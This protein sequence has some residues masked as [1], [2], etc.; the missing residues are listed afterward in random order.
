M[1]YPIL[2]KANATDFRSLGLGVLKDAI[3]CLVTEERNG[4]FELN[5]IY[6][7]SGIHADQ[8]EVDLIIKVDTGHSEIS[9]DQR[10]RI[11]RID[12]RMDGMLEVYANHVSYLAQSLVLEPVVKIENCSAQRALEIW[13]ENMIGAHPFTVMSDIQTSRSTTLTITNQ[14][15]AWQALGGAE[16]SIQNIW[17][18]EYIFDNYRIHLR[19]NRGGNANTLISYGRNL[20]DL[21]QEENI[22][23][24]FTSIY[25]YAIFRDNEQKETILTLRSDSTSDV[26]PILDSENAPYFAHRRVLPIDFSRAFDRGEVLTNEAKRIRLRELAEAYLEEH[27]IGV[28]QVSMSL[29]FV[30][31]TKSLNQ[32]GL[33]YEQLNLCDEVPVYFEKLGIRGRAKVVRVVWDVLLDQYES[34]DFGEMRPGLSERLRVI[35]REV[36]EVTNDANSALT[37]ANGRNTVFFGPDTPVGTRVG[38][39]WYQ[40]NGDDTILWIWNGSGWDFV[41]S[42]APDERLR[43]EIAREMARVE[44]ELERLNDELKNEVKPDLEENARILDELQKELE[45]LDQKLL[46]LDKR[47]EENENELH[48]LNAKTLP[49]LRTELDNLNQTTLPN[50]RRELEE[51][52]RELSGLSDL[53]DEWRYLN[54]VEIDGGSIRANTV[55]TNHMQAGTI[56]GDRIRTGSLHA[57][58]LAANTI[59]GN[60]IHANAIGAGHITAEAINT[61]HM[62]ANTIDGD[63]IHVNTLNGDKVT[64]NTL[65]ANKILAGSITSDRMTANTITGDRIR[66][67][68]LHANRIT[69]DT[70]TGDRIRADAIS[71]NHISAGAI[72]AGKIGANAVTAGNIAAGAVTATMITTGTLNAANLTVINLNASSITAGVMHGDRIEA[73]T[74]NANRIRAN[75]LTANMITTG[76][77]H[78]DRI[79]A[80]TLNANRIRA[81]TLTANMITTGMMH[82]DRIE[83]GTLNANRITTDSITANRLA[84]NAIE[85]RH[86]RSGQITADKLATNAIQVGFNNMGSTLNL[87]STALTFNSVSGNTTTREGMLTGTGLQ[88]WWGTRDVGRI[89]N[90]QVVNQPNIRGI[91]FGLRPGGDY[92]AF[93]WLRQG[94]SVYTNSMV[95]DPIGNFP[96][97]R[98]GINMFQRLSVQDMGTRGFTTNRNFFVGITNINGAARTFIGTSDNYSA[99]IAFSNNNCFLIDNGIAYRVRDLAR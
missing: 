45:E 95:I 49:N 16:S 55:T 30:D 25:P 19:A 6:P 32:S 91:N 97:T 14:Q 2:Y 74:L 82:G 11:D 64:T 92:L 7:I 93:S 9:K 65:N 40:S 75:T 73:G 87:S 77:M 83:A 15:N 98:T 36:Q 85:A 39:L 89:S 62:R 35:E 48:D 42:T 50:V 43:E 80:G 17:G 29:K 99:G 5:M 60:L 28:P 78:G 4:R 61:N 51:L 31:L 23:N 56:D 70:I 38:D 84:T 76:I 12:K 79:E 34:L 90:N 86:I 94:A 44:K 18:G 24:T 54:T 20:I 58:R 69:A 41:M 67:D 68:S 37:A 52:E 3:S 96:G 47:L 26:D 22:T 72:T 1:S 81:N 88:Y 33:T 21:N 27:E 63:R 8:L 13:R 46:I 71:A 57:D 59:T 10:F 53:T 66:T